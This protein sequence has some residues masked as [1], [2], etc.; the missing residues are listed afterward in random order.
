M[1]SSFKDAKEKSTEYLS[2]ETS[3]DGSAAQ[4]KAANRRAKGM[5]E[6]DDLVSR[7]IEEAMSD[8]AFDNLPG[9]GKP[10]Q[11][12][13]NEHVP[14]EMRLAFNLLED[15]DMPPQWIGDRAELQRAIAKFRST[16]QRQ[17][18]WH[19]TRLAE[20]KTEHDR[21]RLTESWKHYVQTWEEE[22]R[23]LNRRIRNLNLKQ[24]IAHL[25]IWQLR[26]DEE[27][28]YAHVQRTLIL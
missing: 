4:Q 17:A 24:P 20:A 27:L 21:F 23:E 19:R 16:I 6:W 12:R 1:S 3:S 18:E 8:G 2:D 14:E 22:I 13:N 25:E 5:H 26:L 7:R 11:K 10:L 15:N 9:R 28:A